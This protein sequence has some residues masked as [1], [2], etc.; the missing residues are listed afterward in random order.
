[1]LRFIT[2]MCEWPLLERAEVEVTFFQITT[3]LAFI[4]VAPAAATGHP[5]K[6][7]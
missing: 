6:S 7:T 1:M 5:F 3:P 4:L 2:L